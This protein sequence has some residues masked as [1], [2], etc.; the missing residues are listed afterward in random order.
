M[1]PLEL[2][3]EEKARRR[4]RVDGLRAFLQ[5][6]PNV[7]R[8]EIPVSQCLWTGESVEV[9]IE[10]EDYVINIRLI[11]ERGTVCTGWRVNGKGVG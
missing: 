4:G 9:V 8:D 6:F 10:L 3:W 1:V 7:V 5:F 2:V 11:F